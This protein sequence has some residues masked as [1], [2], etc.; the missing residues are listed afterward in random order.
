[1]DAPWMAFVRGTLPRSYL[2]GLPV[3]SFDELWIPPSPPAPPPPAGTPP[4][5]T[6]PAATPPATAGPAGTK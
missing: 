6:P 3:R 4:A 1:M 2:S 5:R